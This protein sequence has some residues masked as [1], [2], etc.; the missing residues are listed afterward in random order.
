MTIDEFNLLC[1]V[2]VVATLGAVALGIA[3]AA[4]RLSDN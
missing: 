4:A 1:L 3:L 2:G